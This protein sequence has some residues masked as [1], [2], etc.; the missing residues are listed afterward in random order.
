MF[1]LTLDPG[2]LKRVLF[3]LT[4]TMRFIH[5]SLIQF[6]VCV[7]ETAL[8]SLSLSLIAFSQSQVLWTP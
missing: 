2:A 4:A 5:D 7:L 1:G 8:H 3:S 6:G